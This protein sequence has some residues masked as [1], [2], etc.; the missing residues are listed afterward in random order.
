MATERHQRGSLR[1]NAFLLAGVPIGIDGGAAN[2]RRALKERRRR[3]ILP[4][5]RCSPRGGGEGEGERKIRDGIPP[6]VYRFAF[7]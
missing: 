1:K 7:R 4:A 2:G 5:R 3:W 6:S